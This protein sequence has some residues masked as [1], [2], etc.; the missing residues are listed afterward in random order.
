MT[1]RMTQEA[2]NDHA[3]DMAKPFQKQLLAHL[4]GFGW[5]VQS[6]KQ[7]PSLKVWAITVSHPHGGFALVRPDGAMIRPARGQKSVGWRWSDLEDQAYATIPQF[8]KNMQVA[9]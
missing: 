2:L 3:L 5:Q 6:M 8:P 9:A 1:I 7:S 4:L